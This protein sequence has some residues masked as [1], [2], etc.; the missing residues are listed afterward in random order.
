MTLQD[1]A[2]GAEF[3]ITGCICGIFCLPFLCTNAFSCMESRIMIGN[4]NN[5]L[6]WNFFSC[7]TMVLLHAD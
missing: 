2:K 7:L 4:H 5:G 1:V 3:T 6:I